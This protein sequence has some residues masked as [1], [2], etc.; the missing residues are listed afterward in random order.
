M[1]KDNTMKVKS[2]LVPL[3]FAFLGAVS[4]GAVCLFMLPPMVTVYL[5]PGVYIG[6]AVA[7]VIP[8]ALIYALVPDGGGPAFLLIATTCSIFFWTCIIAAIYISFK[9]L[10]KGQNDGT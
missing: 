5:W 10:R 7:R 3:L 6:G 2:I 1:E 8:S 4:L 9:K